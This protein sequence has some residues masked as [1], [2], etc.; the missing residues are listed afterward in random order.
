MNHWAGQWATVG[1]KPWIHS[2]PYY[3][4]VSERSMLAVSFRVVDIYE[5]KSSHCY[6]FF[7]STSVF[8]HG[9]VFKEWVWRGCAV[10]VDNTSKRYCSVL[11]RHISGDLKSTH[12]V[13]KRPRAVQP[14]WD[15]NLQHLFLFLWSPGLNFSVKWSNTLYGFLVCLVLHTIMFYSSGKISLCFLLSSES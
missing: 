10:V 15:S 12:G 8:S 14:P 5:F 11:S 7:F 2:F 1:S 6:L 3:G 9:C 13:C 4:V